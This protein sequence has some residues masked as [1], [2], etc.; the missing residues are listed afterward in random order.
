[1]RPLLL[2]LFFP[3]LFAHVVEKENFTFS[4]PQTTLTISH[5]PRFPVVGQ[6]VVFR[7]ITDIKGEVIFEIHSADFS[8]KIVPSYNNSS[9][10]ASYTFKEPGNYS[11][12]L[13]IEG[14]EVNP[15]YS[16]EVDA[17]D[18]WDFMQIFIIVIFVGFL[19]WNIYSDCKK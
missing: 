15:N 19:G 13:V 7:V 5:Q 10:V 4:T 16:F 11:L 8:Q 12:H 6:E 14:V 18:F 3:L 2:L 17:L 1:M 9:Y